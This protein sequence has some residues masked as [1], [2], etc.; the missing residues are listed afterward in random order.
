MSYC[1]CYGTCYRTESALLNGTN[2]S[3]FR[4]A[5]NSSNK[6]TGSCATRSD[7]DCGCG[8]DNRNADTDLCPVG[9]GYCTTVIGVVD[10]VVQ[11]V[12]EQIVARKSSACTNVRSGVS[13]DE[14]ADAGIVISALQVIEPGFSVVV[15]ASLY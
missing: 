11:A 14:T 10:G 13:I 3:T 5:V 15:V 1:S 4:N 7:S 8:S 9:Q 12:G 2:Q 6:C